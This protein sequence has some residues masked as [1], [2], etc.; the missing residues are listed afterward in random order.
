MELPHDEAI[1]ELEIM[2][3]E[4]NALREECRREG[5]HF[6]DTSEAFDEV[7]TQAVRFLITGKTN[8]S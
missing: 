2:K 7:L 3:G 6:F 8:S 1:A 5:Y 4:S